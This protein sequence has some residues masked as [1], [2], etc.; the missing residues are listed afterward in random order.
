GAGAGESEEEPSGD[1]VEAA[2]AAA[3][4]GRRINPEDPIPPPRCPSRLVALFEEALRLEAES[5]D[6]AA[7]ETSTPKAGGRGKP[8]R[9]ARNNGSQDRRS[10]LQS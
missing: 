8:R 9:R 4:G 2:M 3:G 1:D 6:Q 5:K 10:T 7:G